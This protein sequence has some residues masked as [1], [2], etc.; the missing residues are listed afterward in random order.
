MGRV[1]ANCPEDQGSIL[2]QV[3]PKTQMVL[4]TSLLN[5]H[6]YKI[7]IMGKLSYPGKEK[8]HSLIRQCSREPSGHP[9]LLLATLLFLALK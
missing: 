6:Y 4:E 8:V 7:R 5:A 2:G 3:I 1:L 9:R